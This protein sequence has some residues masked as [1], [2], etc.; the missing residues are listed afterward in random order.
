MSYPP[1]DE[2][3]REF[4]FQNFIVNKAR[5]IPELQCRLIELIHKPSQAKVLHIQ[6]DDQENL[7]SLSFQTI[8][9]SSNGAA[10]IL[11]HTVL[12]GSEKFP[13]RDPFF[14]MIRRSMNTFMNA[15]TGSDFTCYPASSQIEKDFYNLLEVYLDAVFHP[16][17]HPL[18]FMQEAHRLEITDD[19]KL[20]INGI[21]Y[22]EMKGAMAN[23]YRRLMN[24][25]CKRLFST[26]PYGFDSGGDP[27]EI[28]TITLEDLKKFHASYYHPSRCLFFFYGNLPLAN[29]LAFIEHHILSK[30]PAL[31]PLPPIPKQTPFVA[32]IYD[33]ISYPIT[34]TDTLDQK[35]YLAFGWLTTPISNQLECLALLVLDIVLLETDASPLKY[36]LLQSGLCKQVISSCDVEI[37]EVPFVII[38]TGC[39][40]EDN[41]ALTQLL[42]STLKEIIRSGISKEKI[43]HAL[44][45]LEFAK[46]EISSDQAPFGLSLYSRAALLAHHGID[47]INGLAIHSL[48]HALHQALQH[49]PRFFQKLIQ[50][51]FLDNPHF[52]RLTMSPSRLFE[53]KEREK[54]EKT[55]EKKLKALSEKQ[56]ENIKAQSKELIASQHAEQ[57]LDCLPT[58]SLSDV[59]KECRL[60]PLHRESIG[61]AEVFSHETFTNSITYAT[62]SFPLPKIDT[63]DLWLLRLFST[64]LPQLGC[65]NRTYQETLEYLQAYTGGVRASLSLHRQASD[66]NAITPTWV[67]KGKALDK[68]VDRLFE[69]FSDFLLAPRFD[70]P[71]RIFELL[72]K[73]LT[74][75]E[76]NITSHALDYAMNLSAAPLSA[77]HAI[78]EQWNGI[79]YLKNLKELVRTYTSEQEPFLEKLR[80]LRHSLLLNKGMHI[81]ICGRSKTLLHL[82]ENQFCGLSELTTTPSHPWED[83]VP[84]PS[85]YS[86]QGI[87]I[88]SNVSFTSA[89]I[90]TT[91]YASNDAATLSVLSHL[92]NNVV[93]HQALR[94]QGG[95]YGGGTSCHPLAGTFSFYSY[96]DPNLSSTLKM[97]E[98][99]FAALL[100]EP[101][102][103]SDLTEAKLNILQDLDT[104]I[105]PGS[106]AEVAYSWWKQGR[107]TALR[108]GF[109]EKLFNTSKEDIEEAV[110]KY[111]PKGWSTNRF[112]A[113]AGKELF[114]KEQELLDITL[115]SI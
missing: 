115:H 32:P 58:L 68:N 72:E 42:F 78:L 86:H 102:K 110:S 94:E 22:N 33:S 44:H 31:P 92:V 20:S 55:L 14:S 37:A 36:R 40:E 1:T 113:C 62:I 82:K 76:N 39:N 67:L 54:E 83:P 29:H 34:K 46:S 11:E 79:S 65:G 10:H 4:R 90:Q 112:V 84:P 28:P 16:L 15:L 96:K 43:E 27:D 104:P 87:I 53:E 95:A 59:P 107:D 99:C 64:L 21:V 109:R 35:S 60:T 97:Y 9:S 38:L 70:N 41:D 100:K 63:E 106:R 19:E 98:S 93:L 57:P 101:I 8:P 114:D 26:S 3:V 105:S 51:Y 88:P 77:S 2:F 69:I 85:S 74:D 6:A 108:Q 111:F 56:K 24:E 5:E 80:S 7:F 18:S 73:Q 50:K 75:L 45:Q 52:V 30:A 71:K 12:C 81:T 48:F 103:E 17:L 66:S 61:N 25:L 23:P 47:P 89:V 49:D 13:V 91:S